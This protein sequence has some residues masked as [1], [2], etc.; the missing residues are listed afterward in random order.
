MLCLTETF[1]EK[2][3][4]PLKPLE[5]LLQ[6]IIPFG[7]AGVATQKGTIQE[8]KQKETTRA[9]GCREELMSGGSRRHTGPVEALNVKML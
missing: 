5:A 3:L 8:V 4:D 9:A 1:S 7:L 2:F 6:D